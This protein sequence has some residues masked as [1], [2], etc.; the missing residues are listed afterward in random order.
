MSDQSF[1]G[2][3]LV[4]DT[5]SL[6]KSL[7]V[8]NQSIGVT[9]PLTAQGF[10]GYDGILGLGPVDLT[11][12]T[13]IGA[14]SI[15]TVPDNLSDQGFISTEVIGISYTPAQS[16][17]QS[18]ELT[19]GGTDDSKYVETITYVPITSSSP[20]SSYWGIDLDATYGGGA[21]GTIFKSASG[22]V[23]TGTTLILLASDAFSAYQTATGGEMDQN[24]GLLMITKDQYRNLKSLYFQ[25]GGET[26]ELTRNAQIW[27]RKMNSVINGQSNAIYLVV[28]D[29]SA[30]RYCI[31]LQRR[32]LIHSPQL[33]STIESGLDFILG[34]AFLQRFYS[35]FDT[36]NSRVGLAKTSHTYD[37]SN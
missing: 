7:A 12:G 15:P 4:Y 31:A 5:L 36:T 1:E 11:E 19:F 17:S 18:G 22:I 14:G 27:P 29:V 24:T 21:N 26:F 6:S 34:Y 10:T 32:E 13:V 2:L 16:S 25:V 28:S 33:G 30:F 20:S 23:D 3:I 35:V 9:T 37:T 8:Q